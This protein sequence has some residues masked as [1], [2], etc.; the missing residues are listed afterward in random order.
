MTILGSVPVKTRLPVAAWAFATLV[1]FF[2]LMSA[3]IGGYG[4]GEVHHASM[5]QLSG[6]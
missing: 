3:L 6:F 1:T 4:V 2:S 5:A